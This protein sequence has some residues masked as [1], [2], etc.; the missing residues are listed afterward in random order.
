[1]PLPPP[2]DRE[3]MHTRDIK[4]QGFRR[5]DGQMDVEAHLTDTKGFDFS[6]PDRGAISSGVPFRWRSW[7][8]RVSSRASSP[9]ETQTSL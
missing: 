8:M 6:N 2:V 5:A 7:A 1:M 4:L 3:L 9:M